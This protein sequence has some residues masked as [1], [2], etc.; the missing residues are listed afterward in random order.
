M[1][2]SS[3]LSSA[4]SFASSVSHSIGHTLYEYCVAGGLQKQ[5]SWGGPICYH[6]VPIDIHIYEILAWSLFIL[7][8]YRVCRI[9][10]ML[11]KLSG[12]A[13]ELLTNQKFDKSNN[14]LINN[15]ERIVDLAL[16][17]LHTTSY[18]LLLYYKTNLHSLINMFQPCHMTLLFQALALWS[19]DKF[20]VEIGVL[21]LP[22]TLGS[23]MAILWPATDG[24]NQPFE[25]ESFWVLHF[26]I[27]ATPLYLLIRK[28]FAAYKLA[29]VQTL[30]LG[31]YLNMIFHWWVVE[32]LN[33]HFMVNINFMLCP[34]EA[35]KSAFDAIGWIVNCP[36]YRSFMCAAFC[37]LN[38]GLAY[39]YILVAGVLFFGFSLAAIGHNIQDV[40]RGIENKNI[41]T[42]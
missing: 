27:Q 22:M 28:N 31:N 6:T 13:Q 18:I 20:G 23:L 38:I 39:V 41:K 17:C 15:I 10:R 2:S 42:N 16:L 34:A 37:S 32:P 11:S 12:R 40:D 4:S 3:S 25:L 33:L 35:M 30:L 26:L 24:L 5:G 7:V 8:I 14:A 29:N 19:T 21:L 9:D 1:S 36:S